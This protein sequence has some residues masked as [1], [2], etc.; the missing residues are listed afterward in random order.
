MSID[1]PRDVPEQWRAA[2]DRKG[3][4]FTFRALESKVPGVAL[5]TIIRALSGEGKTSERVIRAISTALG[6]TTERFY[7]LR[8]EP[9]REPFILPSRANQLSGP[10][11]AVVRDV[12]NAILDARD[13]QR[14]DPAAGSG[15]FLQRAAHEASKP[16]EGTERP[17]LASRRT[18]VAGIAI[19]RGRPIDVDEVFQDVRAVYSDFEAGTEQI[20]EVYEAEG[21]KEGRA[22]IDRFYFVRDPKIDIINKLYDQINPE[23]FGKTTIRLTPAEWREWIEK[24]TTA[25]AEFDLANMNI[26]AK[27]VEIVP[28][29]Q[30]DQLEGAKAYVEYGMWHDRVS[31]DALE[32]MMRFWGKHAQSAELIEVIKKA[33]RLWESRPEMLSRQTANLEIIERKLREKRAA[34]ER[35]DSAGTQDETHRGPAK[36]APGESPQAAHGYSE[37]VDGDLSGRDVTHPDS[38]RARDQSK[39]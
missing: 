33:D 19:V 14:V 32:W 31:A 15:A 9:V 26:Q 7:E 25:M 3:I 38:P 29:S 24:L 30:I 23:V 21:I 4:E 37:F 17:T 12:I 28:D 13:E 36:D 18:G 20:Y 11:R 27:I 35:A 1:N 10:E 16:A 6:I 34:L 22:H 8:G 5:N 39:R 2:F